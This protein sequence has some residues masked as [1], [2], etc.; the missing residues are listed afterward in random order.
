MKPEKKWNQ[1]KAFSGNKLNVSPACRKMASTWDNLYLGTKKSFQDY[2]I[3]YASVAY[4]VTDY[5]SSLSQQEFLFTTQAEIQCFW[6]H[7]SSSFFPE[8]FNFPVRQ[9]IYF[10]RKH[11]ALS[12][13]TYW[14]SCTFV[15]LL[16]ARLLKNQFQPIKLA[17][18]RRNK[19]VD[20][21]IF[22]YTLE[23][24]KL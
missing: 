23:G 8:D 20:F 11:F 1:H 16:F 13:S 4:F 10:S 9:S 14:V 19:L 21:L 12:I 15:P 5:L 2:S 6:L 3:G 24:C 18:L 17:Y 22:T 7:E